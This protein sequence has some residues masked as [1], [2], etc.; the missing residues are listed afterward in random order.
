[1]D[2]EDQ[3]LS[4]DDWKALRA[5]GAI[6]DDTLAKAAPQPNEAADVETPDMSEV[7]DDS[8]LG[9]LAKAF[10]AGSDDDE[11][12]EQPKPGE[13]LESYTSQG[14]G[15]LYG[16]ATSGAAAV[17]AAS[18]ETAFPQ[19]QGVTPPPANS[20]NAPAGNAPTGG[21]MNL[22][23]VNIDTGQNPQAS[24]LE[25]AQA[26]Y[27]GATS[28]VNEATAALK[29]SIQG[30]A[31]GQKML[32]QETVKTIQNYQN[33]QAA[34]AAE[35]QKF[36][37]QQTQYLEDKKQKLDQLAA[38][39]ADPSKTK[40][41][42]GRL[43]ANASTGDK[44]MGGIALIFGALGTGHTGGVN[45]AAKAMTD[46]VMRDI[47]VQKMNIDN[48]A[49]A[50]KMQDSA[51]GRALQTF[52]DKN[53]A[54]HAATTMGLN[55]LKVQLEQVAA[56]YSDPIIQ[57]KANQA[58]AQVDLQI[59]QSQQQFFAAQMNSPFMVS[60]NNDYNV[61][62]RFVP[63]K[64]QESV[65]KEY[66]DSSKYAEEHQAVMSDIDKL[67]D[68]QQG[69]T[70][71]KDPNQKYQQVQALKTGIAQKLSRMY[72]G[73]VNKDELTMNAGKM[74]TNLF[75]NPETISVKRTQLENFLVSAAPRSLSLDAFGINPYTRM[76]QGSKMPSLRKQ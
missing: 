16:G 58:L 7:K 11:K 14:L 37:D 6:N 35:Y 12:P 24:P 69:K 28:K 70:Y 57:G 42:S 27:M 33:E 55:N 23:N 19:T 45:L 32:N 40:I 75:D 3:N 8:V 67:T 10:G 46:A 31:A 34:R 59:A 38:D 43:W 1:M 9:K 66:N 76:M 65:L 61:I 51:Y 63:E 49:M 62:Q 68:I 2:N 39:F 53:V 60:H 26:A 17:P 29:D 72:D 22:A 36:S 56:Q 54:F 13:R 5:K 47:E 71:F 50:F 44:I 30:Q 52:N 18:T 20:Y 73:R 74:L 41:D 4:Q 48:K 25:A 15:G 21:N 64:Q